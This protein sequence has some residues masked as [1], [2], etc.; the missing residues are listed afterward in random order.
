MIAPTVLEVN[1]L[2]WLADVS[3]RCGRRCTL[4]DVPTQE[5]D[6]LR[7][8]GT[9][10]IWLM[11]V[12]QRSPAGAAILKRNDGHLSA[13]DIALPGWGDD[14]FAGSAYCIRGYQ[15][16][17]RLGGDAALAT[18]RRELAKRGLKLVLDFVPNH[19]APDHPWTASHPERFIRGGE[20]DIASDPAAFVRCGRQVLACGRDPYFP[21]WSDV[22]QL[23][24]FHP[25]AREALIA[26]LV[27]IAGRCDGIRCDM[28]MLA[29]NDVVEKTWGASRLQRE[30]R[31]PAGEFWEEA[32]AAI[33]ERHPGCWLAAECYWSLEPRLRGLGFDACYEKAPF[34]AVQRRD[35]DAFRS[36]LAGAQG[37]L[38]GRL[39]FAENHDEPRVAMSC[40]G[41]AAAALVASLA[42]PGPRL[43]HLGQEEGRRVHLPVSLA[44]APAEAGDHNLAILHRSLLAATSRSWVRHGAAAILPAEGDPAIVAWSLRDGAGMAVAAINLGWHAADARLRL[45]WPGLAGL[46][47][48]LRDAV[49]GAEYRR[50]GSEMLSPGLFVRIEA[51]SAHL[52]NLSP[53]PG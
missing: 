13:C 22:V 6:A 39:R 29:L 52:F 25:G 3:A 45:S 4:A 50:S 24:L 31:R 1:T 15:V 20:A 17:K 14:D 43:L 16:D 38:D 12:W 53:A 42:L 32:V 19:V 5:W 18:A 2:P 37:D 33:R 41:H 47:W 11:G 51:G 34:D 21:P 28:A 44:R 10:A 23:D 26:T 40:G 35:P 46:D 9:D 48:I 7:W 36:W 8:P 30:T 49:T 27:A